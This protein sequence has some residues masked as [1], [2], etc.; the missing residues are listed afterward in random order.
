LFFKEESSFCVQF[1]KIY[2]VPHHGFC[3]YKQIQHASNFIESVTV[4]F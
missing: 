4:V 1:S 2:D 3:K